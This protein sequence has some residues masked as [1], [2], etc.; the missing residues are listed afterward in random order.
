MSKTSRFFGLLLV[1]ALVLSLF[2]GAV[3]AQDKVLNANFGPGDIPSLDPSLATDTTSIQVLVET[4][5]GLTRL[6]EVTLE[7]EPGMASS[8]D[9]S[10]DGLTY[11]FHL[12][13][14]VPWVVVKDG[15]V[16]QVMDADG[17]GRF[18]TA[19]DFVFGTQRSMNPDVGSYYGGVLAPWIVNGTAV[20]NGEM[21]LSELG[22]TAVD[23][24]TL[25]VQLTE[26]AAFVPNL[27]GMWMAVAQPE[28]AL[29]EF[30]DSW[31]EAGN[32]PTYGPFALGE[33]NHGE[34]L[35]LVKNPMWVGTD[36]IPAPKLDAVSFTM[37]DQSAQLASY[38]SGSL[39][40][41]AAPL[42][43]MDRLMADATLSQ[44]L[45]IGP[46]SCTYYYGFN[47][48]KA[49]VDDARVRRALSMAIDRQSLIDNVLKGGQ[50]A[51]FFFTR[52]N[53]VAAPTAEK[54]PDYVIGED[55]ETAKA[56]IADYVA[57]V[58]ELA[59]ITLMHNES[60]AHGQIAQAIQ[61]MWADNLGITVDIQ[62]QEWAVYLDTLDTADAP[63]IWRLGWCLDYPDTHNFLYDVFQSDNVRV[64]TGWAGSEGS[65]RFDE[66]VTAA[67]GEQDLQARTDLYAQADYLLSNE[68][69]VI[70]PIYF[71]TFVELTKPYV[72]RTYSVMGQ[73]Y[74]EKWDLNN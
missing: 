28:W 13:Q 47:T 55:V 41:S 63:Q 23:D 12:L 43:D 36:S 73:E 24:Y 68:E 4:H 49:P 18:V 7:I 10:E 57:E 21:E 14:E 56:L 53:L 38:E 61:Q 19:A 35:L 71:Y 44:E 11:T 67:K 66:L 17:N 69:A 30:G 16:M 64:G 26:N 65:A 34:S 2:M 58:G 40:K 72:E 45:T 52:P 8:W 31:V 25:E 15:E 42:A 32:F 22:I 54:Y 62:T 33:W 29:A 9:V 70:I 51:A 3:S 1:T 39:D 46:G 50:E 48:A 37:L 5:P 74:F 59:P 60:E 27:L 20:Y 6:N